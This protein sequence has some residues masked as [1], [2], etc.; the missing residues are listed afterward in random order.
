MLGGRYLTWI[1]ASRY[2]ASKHKHDPLWT[3]Q[4]SLFWLRLKNQNKRLISTVPGVFFDE[5]RIPSWIL[6]I[7]FVELVSFVDFWVRTCMKQFSTSHCWNIFSSARSY[8]HLLFFIHL[9]VDYTNFMQMTPYD[10]PTLN[11]TFDAFFLPKFKQHPT[12]FSI[13]FLDILP[14]TVI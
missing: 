3:L 1:F 12:I 11:A 10:F 5:P 2:I 13:S 6:S 9:P 4:L 8:T 7:D 14:G